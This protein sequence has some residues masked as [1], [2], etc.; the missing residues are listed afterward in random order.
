MAAKNGLLILRLQGKQLIIENPNAN[1]QYTFKKYPQKKILARYLSA[2][3]HSFHQ[4]LFNFTSW[5]DRHRD[6]QMLTLPSM[7][8]S[9]YFYGF[10]DTFHF[11][12]FA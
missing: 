8:R 3:F 6:K 12:T 2:L 11:T 5:T 4:K 9:A 1:L 7:C 10:Y